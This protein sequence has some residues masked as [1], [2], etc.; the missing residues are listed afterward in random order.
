MNQY[1]DQLTAAAQEAAEQLGENMGVDLGLP[2]V[3]GPGGEQLL[4][5]FR[6][7]N[8]LDNI[9][10]DKE[11]TLHGFKDG[12]IQILLIRAALFASPAAA[13]SWRGKKITQLKP[14]TQQCTVSTV[15][16]T[17]ARF[18]QFVLVSRQPAR[19]NTNV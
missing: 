17:D 2:N 18:Y 5:T 7:A 6:P 10:P 15:T 3:R 9:D 8:A 14:V 13:L 11:M 19:E 1:D 12:E 16:V 4:G